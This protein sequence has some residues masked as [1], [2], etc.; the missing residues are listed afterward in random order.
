[1][2][3][4]LRIGAWA[5]AAQRYAAFNR[6]AGITPEQASEL[7]T[8][9]QAITCLYGSRQYAVMSALLGMSDLFISITEVQNPESAV[10]IGTIGIDGANRVS[11]G[12]TQG[13]ASSTIYG[14]GTA[15]PSLVRK[16]PSVLA[17]L[18]QGAPSLAR[19]PVPMP[20]YEW[21]LV[22]VSEGKTWE[23][24]A[25]LIYGELDKIAAH[26]PKEPQ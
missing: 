7:I 13:L 16:T 24:I 18:M 19:K 11:A 4:E 6:E 23:G 26:F 21:A 22:M 5:A 9:M 15:G 14:W 8:I 25:E 2:G 12:P 17:A 10:T 3:S 1:M 20:A